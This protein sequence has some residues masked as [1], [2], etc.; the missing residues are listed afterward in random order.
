MIANI[1][2]IKCVTLFVAPLLVAIFVVDD[3]EIS[4]WRVI[5]LIFAGISFV[6]NA[7]FCWFATDTPAK[8]TL[9]TEK[10]REPKW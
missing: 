8:F 5:F 4:Q 10:V 7:I 3:T 9:V 6:A 1:Q 2:F